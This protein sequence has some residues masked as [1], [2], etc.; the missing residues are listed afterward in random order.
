[1]HYIDFRNEQFSQLIFG[2]V[3]LGLDYGISNL[4]GQ[5]GRSQSVEMLQYAYQHGVNTFDTARDY[6]TS[7]SVIAEAQK[8]MSGPVKSQIMTKFKISS[9]NESNFERAWSEVLETVKKSLEVLELER[10]NT[11][12]FHRSPANDLEVVMRLLPV[13]ISRLKEINLIENGGFSAFYPADVSYALEEDELEVIQVP[14]NLFDHRFLKLVPA[15]KLTNKLVIARSIFLQGLF[16][17]DPDSLTGSLIA[18][19]QP[20]RQLREI[21]I[22][23]NLTIEQLAVAFVRD[24]PQVDCLVI[25]AISLDQITQNIALMQQPP[26][27]EEVREEILDTFSQIDPMVVTPVLWTSKNEKAGL[28]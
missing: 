13:I 3:Q 26:I 24:Q 1:M 8:Q 14:C 27:S 10:I 7:E 19:R 28:S 25:G 21:A 22:R 6:G 11:L 20:L 4:T 15:E 9:F 23:H 18:A 17:M 12:M 16:F 5:P 2:T